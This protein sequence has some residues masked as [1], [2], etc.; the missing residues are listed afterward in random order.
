MAYD[1]D[2]TVIGYRLDTQTQGFGEGLIAYMTQADA[3]EWN[4]FDDVALPSGLHDIGATVAKY[5]FFFPEKREIT[6]W[7]HGWYVA[8]G[9]FGSA[10]DPVLQG[11]NDT[12]SGIDGTWETASF[13][14]GLPDFNTFRTF[15]DYW[16]STIKPISFTGGKTVI[17]FY[18]GAT[19]AG[20]PSAY[21]ARYLHL[22]GEKFIGETVHDII[23]IDHD[24]T[25]GVEYQTDED[26]GDRPL[27]TTVVRQFRIKN[28]SATRTAINISIQCNDS[29]FAISTD[30]VTY[31]VT[32]S[33][34]SLAPGAE[35]AT[36]YIRNTTPAPGA[37]LGPRHAR[38][39]TTAEWSGGS[40]FFAP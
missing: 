34:G 15:I 11:S 9:A 3:I 6:A 12:T 37:I 36:M 17:R 22:Y 4:D 8:P 18:A 39:V 13:P 40:N 27:G 32:I 21:Q 2:G 1:N 5:W 19:G 23:Y 26:F 24:T 30:N 20:G 38:I 33:L 16:R 29:D 14:S 10:V 31:V 25:P 7:S 35:S 28:T